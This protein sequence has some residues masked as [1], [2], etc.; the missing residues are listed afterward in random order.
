MR[1]PLVPMVVVLGLVVVAAGRVLADEDAPLSAKDIQQVRGIVEKASKKIDAAFANVPERK[2]MEADLA[3]LSKIKDARERRKAADKYQ[4]TYQGTYAAAVKAAGVDFQQLAK[5]MG[6]AIRRRFVVEQ[7]YLLTLAPRRAKKR[8]GPIP[9]RP[10]GSEVVTL[11]DFLHERDVSTGAAAG[12]GVD[13]GDDSVHA[14]VIAIGAGGASAD[15]GLTKEYAVP[16]DVRTATLHIRCS[17]EADAFAVGVVG[18]SASRG[19]A[20]AFAASPTGHDFFEP[21]G[22]VDATA[23]APILWV[24]YE[25]HLEEVEHEVALPLGTTVKIAFLAGA[26]GAAAASPETDGNGKVFDIRATV[27]LQH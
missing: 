2:K 23:F 21:F 16:S 26:F 22:Y 13:F 15:G 9:V 14:G 17:V 27:T 6:D 5:D 10:K 4:K 11:T 3:A 20:D 8:S 19:D 12:G 25:D 24:G 7:G 18:T 1:M